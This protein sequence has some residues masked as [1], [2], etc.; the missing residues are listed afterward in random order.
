MQTWGRVF[1]L[2]FRPHVAYLS[3]WYSYP[4]V[5]WPRPR[6]CLLPFVCPP[7]AFPVRPRCPL[8]RFHALDW[9]QTRAF[10]P[11]LSCWCWSWRRSWWY[12]WRQRRWRRPRRR[13]RQEMASWQRAVARYKE[14]CRGLCF[15]SRTRGGTPR[16]PAAHQK[17]TALR[18]RCVAGLCARSVV[19][20]KAS[21]LCT[22][23]LTLPPCALIK[24]VSASRSR[25]PVIEI[26]SPLNK[27]MLTCEPRAFRHR[28]QEI[29]LKT[30]NVCVCL[31]VCV[32]VCVCVFVCV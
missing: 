32:C 29:V 10:S 3:F 11:L 23:A 8:P 24:D 26:A 31:C 27:F 30:L 15:A 13:R 7:P 12:V 21:R 18:T 14:P 17:R 9:G 19:T 16:T 22:V 2:C 25:L 28:T 6:F 1:F 20:K 5:A 4:F